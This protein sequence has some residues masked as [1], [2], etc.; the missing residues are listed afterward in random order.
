MK[1][2]SRNE[3]MQSCTRESRH[4]TNGMLNGG[5]GRNAFRFIP[6]H[7]VPSNVIP[8]YCKWYHTTLPNRIETHRTVIAVD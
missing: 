4:F 5:T 6:H 1:G 8:T 7:E 2:T 3:W